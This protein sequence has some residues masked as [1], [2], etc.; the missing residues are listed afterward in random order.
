M[1]NSFFKI[2]LIIF[3]YFPFLQANGSDEFN[4][5]ITEVQI[6]EKGNKFIGS[7]RGIITSSDG[8]VIDADRFEYD[9][10]KNILRADGKVKITDKINQYTILTES[11]IFVK[12]D[13]LIFTKNKS[14]ATSINDNIQISANEFE[15]DRNQN[16][17]S[18]YKNVIIENKIDNYKIFSEFINYQINQG[19]FKTKGDVSGEVHSKYNFKSKDLIFNK[20]S[21][22]L[23]SRKE[24]TFTDSSNF[25]KFKKFNYS[26]N[27]EE[28]KGENVLINSNYKS[29]KNDKFY[30]SSAIINLR[31]QEYIAKDPQI[32]IHKTIFGN[33]DNDPRLKGVSSVKK[34][35]VTV[36]KKGIFTSCKEND[37]C[38]PWSIEAN[39]IKHDGNKKQMIYKNALLRVYDFPVFYFPKF[40]HP[41]PSVERQTGFLK[42][43]LNNS[44]VLGSSLTVPY[45]KV[46]SENKD[47]TFTPTIFDNDTLSLQNEY[48]QENKLSSIEV[49]FGYVKNYKS[50]SMNERK[51]LSHLFLNYEL[52]LDIDNFDTSDLSLSLETVT[53]DTYLKVFEQY[54][55]KSNTRPSD[56]NNLNSHLK[57]YLNNESFNFESGFEVYENLQTGKSDR[58][59]YILPYYNFEKIINQDFYDGS[60][61]FKSHGNNFLKDTNNL[62]SNII[63]D[64]RFKSPNFISSIGFNNSYNINLKNLNSI[65]KNNSKYKSSPQI[66]LVGLFN[67]DSSL[68][69]FKVNKNNRST[70]VPKINFKFNPNDMKNYTTSDNKIDINNIFNSNRLGFSD[71][72]EGGR[73]LTLGLDYKRESK[74]SLNEINKYFEL[75]LATVLRDKKEDF[76]PK[77]ST[78]NRKSSNLFGSI[79]NQFSDNLSLN[80][81]F[82]IDNDYSKFE[83]N[84]LGATLSINNLI[85]SF[86]FIEE[87]GE[88]GDSN[89]FENSIRYEFNESNFI[90]FNTRRNRKLDLTEYDD[91]VYQYKNDCLTAGIRFKKSYYEDR[92]LKPTEDLLFTITLF[93]LTTYEYEA[94]TF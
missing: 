50:N 41:D 52:D 61:Y 42:P 25:Y 55:T 9:K 85:T 90:S 21:M 62:L 84:D 13:D 89:V 68:P 66:E 80:Y 69:M 83:Y 38:P 45:F 82:S 37:D 47:I 40:F 7:K 19:I 3:I 86:S 57:F 93:P 53:N 33:D 49:D 24:T 14:K 27:K 34:G 31:S 6:L 17:I 48:R 35:N 65:S 15:Y 77:K 92:D 39:E 43:E 28:L 22:E 56:F 12:N 18:A 94:Q 58:H 26:I 10:I 75:K 11:I 60:V 54:I 91:L 73:S 20:N 8:I 5:D 44:N 78:I 70:L 4:F 59:Q 71:T 87:N 46:I 63:N 2:I 23:N 36:I 72:L 81:N 76:I 64:L 32:K 30:F 67:F 79:T 88:M 29:P 51:N 16:I 74:N 1:K